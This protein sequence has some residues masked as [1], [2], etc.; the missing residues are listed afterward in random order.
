MM[1]VSSLSSWFPRLENHTLP[2]SQA[3]VRKRKYFS[4]SFGENVEGLKESE[5][6]DIR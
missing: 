5:N 3:V 4:E 1:T 6:F 2:P